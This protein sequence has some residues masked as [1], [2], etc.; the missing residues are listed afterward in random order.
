MYNNEPHNKDNIKKVNEKEYHAAMSLWSHGECK[1]S[2]NVS[3]CV[4]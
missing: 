4:Q 3:S 2:Y 1:I